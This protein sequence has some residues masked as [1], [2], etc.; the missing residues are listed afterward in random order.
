MSKFYCLEVA[1]KTDELKRL[2]AEY[3]DYN[4][5]VL[6][7]EEANSG[8][9]SWMYCSSIQF[10]VEEILD[11]D[12]TGYNEEVFTDRGELEEFI[13]E[14][15]ANDD[16]EGKPDEWYEEQIKKKLE[17]LEPFWKKVICIWATN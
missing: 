14:M 1:K 13:G 4:I 16:D 17:E 9:Y 2:I 10:S 15:L 3:P 11:C 6:A 12:Y 5:V 7:G 8:D